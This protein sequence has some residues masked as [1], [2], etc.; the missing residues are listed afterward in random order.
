MLA[1][2]LRPYDRVKTAHAS[3]A[4]LGRSAASD[5][6]TRE[7]QAVFGIVQGAFYK[8]LRIESAKVLADM[9]FPGY[10]IGG[11][12]VGE[13]KPIMYEHAGRDDAV[14]ADRTSRAI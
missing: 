1:V 8:D 4:S 3:H 6:H 2:S 14:Y 12:S 13:P 10:G 11:L 7:D 9:D 5:D